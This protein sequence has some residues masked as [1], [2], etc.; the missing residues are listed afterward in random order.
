MLIH[1]YIHLHKPGSYTPILMIGLHQHAS[2]TALLSAVWIVAIAG[3]V[4]SG[5][6]IRTC[7]E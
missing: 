1:I 4:F 2:A 3:A 6:F 7:I 5:M